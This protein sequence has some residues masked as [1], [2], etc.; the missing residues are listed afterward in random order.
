MQ[1]ELTIINSKEE[2]LSK[3]V[4][5]M[6]EVELESESVKALF[7]EMSEQNHSLNEK[8]KAMRDESV[9]KEEF[10]EVQAQK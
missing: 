4:K 8:V 6:K 5:L 3:S 10:G 7:V 9:L 1:E 2:K